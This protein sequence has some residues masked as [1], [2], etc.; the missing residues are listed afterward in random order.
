MPG[1]RARWNATAHDA[2]TPR[3][4]V[5]P[6]AAPA[7]LWG[8][9]IPPGPV[10]V[11]PPGAPQSGP[12]TWTR[13]RE[14]GARMEQGQPERPP[15]GH[16]PRGLP[17]FLRDAV[18]YDDYTIVDGMVLAQGPIRTRYRPETYP[19][20]PQK[21]AR[22]VR[23]DTAAVL[24]FV[25][26]YGLLGYTQLAAA[27]GRGTHS[28]A[29]GDPLAWV[30]AQAETVALCLHL[31]Y[32]LQAGD[33]AALQQGLRAWQ[34]PQPPQ[35]A[36]GPTLMVPA[37]WDQPRVPLCWASPLHRP[38]DWRTY[39][40]TVRRDILNAHLR[41]ILPQMV[42]QGALDAPGCHFQALLAMVYW[43]LLHVSAY[44]VV[45]RCAEV[46]CRAFFLQTRRTQRFCPAEPPARDSQCA[47]RARRR[48]GQQ[49]A[50]A[51]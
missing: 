29:V 46:S 23:G 2:P 33:D 18:V 14:T 15:S 26:T 48:G 19:E 36:T 28:P 30:W 21:L 45:Q 17:R 39:A 41:G 7:A 47:V 51:E 31:T 25:R 32:G 1:G 43:H 6:C 27:V 37:V 9:V 49:H 8:I 10:P 35:P 3:G 12:P 24:A 22:V 38:E 13:G 40:R 20:L 11:C 5:V 42:D 34:L 50:P 16:E 44:G 4:P